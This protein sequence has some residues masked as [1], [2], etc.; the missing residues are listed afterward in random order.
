MTQADLDDGRLIVTIGAA[1]LRPAEF[2]VV[3]IRKLVRPSDDR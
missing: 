3:S 2:V 1:P